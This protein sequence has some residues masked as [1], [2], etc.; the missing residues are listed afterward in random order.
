MKVNILYVS[1][2]CSDDKFKE[3]FKSS[4][5]KPSQQAQKFHSLLSKGLMGF[6][7]SMYIMSRPPVNKFRN[8]KEELK[9]NNNVTYHY[10]NITDK[11]ILKHIHLLLNGLI[12]SCKWAF[13]FRKLNRVIIC[14][15]LNLSISV[16]A[17]I[18]SKL[19][20]IKSVAIVTDIPHYMQ[21]YSVQKKSPTKRMISNIYTGVCN[22]FMYRY[23]SYIV[24]TEQMNDLVN[25]SKKPY[26][27]IEGMVDI[28]MKNS[29]N[30][31]DNKYDEKIVIYAGALQ[32]MYGVKKLIK[33]FM[34]LQNDNTQLW[35]YG[36]GELESEIR[37]F[38][39]E[40]NRIKYFGVVSNELVVQE[41]LKATLLVNPRPSNEEFTKYSFPSKN[42]EY[43]VS[44]TP[45]LTTPLQGMPEEY[46]EYVY[47]FE[48]ETI[49]G[50]R[51][52]LE[53]ILEKDKKELSEQGN[54]AKEFVLREKNNKIQANKIMKMINNLIEESN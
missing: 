11:P 50:L 54:K 41:Q 24:L 20:G 26:V 47:L 48:N 38:E 53:D 22:F 19:L 39:V 8:E 40:D 2:L 28:N 37:N 29:S 52:T 21:N 23:D 49:D 44:G 43:M 36:S 31:L 3:L 33:A 12:N 14:D 15:V 34:G 10:L 18:T 51:K 1:S 27:V 32:E 45:I 25:P 46:N 35:L 17:F 6:S 42:M 16:S 30:L 13:K 9:N 5:N 7:E 4:H